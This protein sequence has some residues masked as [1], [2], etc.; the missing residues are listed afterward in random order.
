MSAK[1]V[2]I[3]NKAAHD[4]TKA[5]DFGQVVFCTSGPV[6]REAMMELFQQIQQ[7]FTDAEPSDLIMNAGPAS[8]V[9]LACSIMAARFGELHMLMWDKGRYFVR[10]FQLEN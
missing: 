6:R 9:A 10:S 4:Y 8:A 1:K 3:P 2:F 7:S 5:A